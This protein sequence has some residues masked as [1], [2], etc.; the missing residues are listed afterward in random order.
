MKN[1]FNLS[2]SEP[3]HESFK[4]FPKT[5]KGGFCA[6]CTKEVIDF[7]QMISEDIS[8]YFR[9]KMT[10][11]TCGRFTKNQLNTT[12]QPKKKA[13]LFNFL[14]GIAVICVS[15]F[16]FKTEA[17]NT[18]NTT[19]DT[20]NTKNEDASKENLISVKGTVLSSDD[21]L[22]LPG[23]NVIL[24]GSVIGTQTN[25]DGYFEF[26]QKLKKG[27]VLIFSY[28]GLD[29]KKITITENTNLN[30]ELEVNMDSCEIVLMG[31]VAVKEVYKSK[32]RN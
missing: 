29:T 8:N 19:T 10:T 27:D 26:P 28:V 4:N 6:S 23:A 9:N 18:T 5:A 3:C 32:R 7:T 31:K 15:L 17:Q 14:S 1:Q 16:S 30:I 12:I 24:E 11:D 21:G 13:K 20:N 22:P 2:I 25:F